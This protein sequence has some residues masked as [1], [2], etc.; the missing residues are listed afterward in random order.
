[1][2]VTAQLSGQAFLRPVLFLKLISCNR[3]YFIFLFY[4]SLQDD[5]FEAIQRR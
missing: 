5:V 1:M 4:V 2:T 3:I